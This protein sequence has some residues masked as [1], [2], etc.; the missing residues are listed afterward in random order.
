M[1]SFLVFVEKIINCRLTFMPILLEA[2]SL[3][4][5]FTE[6]ISS[7]FI[8]INLEIKHFIVMPLLSNIAY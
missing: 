8:E 1:L 2:I 3:Y 4:S 7:H 5:S 6:V